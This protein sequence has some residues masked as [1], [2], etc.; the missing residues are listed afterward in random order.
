[1]PESNLLVTMSGGTTSVINATLV[2]I[3]ETARH[4]GAMNRVYAGFPGISGILEE[5][6][7][8][9]TDISVSDLRKLYY[10]PASGLIGTTRVSI[11]NSDELA[12]LGGVFAAHRITHFI[13]I[14]GNG[15]VRQSVQ[16]AEYMGTDL[17]VAA[18]PKTVDNDL[19]DAA[20]EKMLFTP[21]F[22]SCANYWRHKVW[23]MNQ[24]NL[25][26][27]SHD[28]VLI[29]QTFGRKTGFLAGCARL[30]DRDRRM[31][32]IILLPEDERPVE[33]VMAAVESTVASRGRAMVVMSEGYD[34]GDIGE[35]Y[36]PTGQVMYGT[37]RTTAAQLLVNL[38]CDIGIQA[39]AFVPGF[40][41]RSDISF[42]SAVDLEAAY[43]T[44][45]NIIERMAAGDRC[46][47]ACIGHGEDH[48]DLVYG[49]LQFDKTSN[50]SRTM[51]ERWVSN[52]SFD[53]TDDY[54]DYVEPLI[55][56]VPVSL[57]RRGA[58]PDFA[59][60]SLPRVGSKLPHWRSCRDMAGMAHCLL[61]RGVRRRVRATGSAH[62]VR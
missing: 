12:R 19:G 35:R 53:V 40:D 33:G 49:S 30:A 42:V 24:E 44:G 60:V 3:V 46:F 51:P 15:T 23:M 13:N 48:M 59:V 45:C 11:L 39:R 10:T 8:D 18:A 47:L 62:L 17:S 4:S 36:D 7:V 34:V 37:S 41:Q 6:I 61:G 26:A 32:L 31:P 9:L 27:C 28:K 50:N 20:F 25:G 21:G 16:I 5:S 38:C 2:G 43:M 1:M 29:A 52:G 54:V 57:P 55:G 58:E 56:D 22:P 14:G